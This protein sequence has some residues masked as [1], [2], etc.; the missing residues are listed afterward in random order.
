MTRRT[1]SL[2]IGTNGLALI[3]LGALH[4]FWPPLPPPAVEQVSRAMVGSLVGQ[5]EVRRQGGQAWAA[6][7][8]GDLLE[9]GDEVRTGLFSEASLHLK[10]AAAVTI[11]PNTSFVVGREQD[12][13]SAFELAEGRITAALA[14]EGQREF[15]FYARGS[16]AVASAER[17]QFSVASDGRGT[18]VV[19]T[20]E[21]E[22]KLAAKGGEVQVGK[23]R[24]STVLPDRPPAPALPI[25]P[26]V[27]L[28]VRWP[29]LKTDK[30]SA[31]LS[32]QTTV[33]GVVTINGILVRA[34]AE[35]N[36]QVDVPLREGQNRLV[37]HAT[38][39]SGNSALRESP[40]ILVDTRPPA[41]DV[42]AK[43]LWK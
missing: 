32:G 23:G 43:G 16:D 12:R 11:D 4:A 6:A 34:D 37:V 29:A 3:T 15:M 30:T 21:G 19:D 2:W 33:G 20:R 38:D 18:V 1:A 9:E 39:P 40:P 13:A 5:V 7:R 41:L 36:F 14:R 28:Q 42:D 17:G 35:G 26:S 8:L 31:R 22:V 27:A 25:P 24:R 10:D